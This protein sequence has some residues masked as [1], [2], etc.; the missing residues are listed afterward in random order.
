MKWMESSDE[1]GLDFGLFLSHSLLVGGVVVAVILGELLRLDSLSF[2]HSYHSHSLSL[3]DFVVAFD[4]DSA[5]SFGFV[6]FASNVGLGFAI[7]VRLDDVVP[8]LAFSSVGSGL[9][10]CFGNEVKEGFD[11]Y[12]ALYRQLVAFELF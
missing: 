1:L 4:D 2:R 12:L 3:V 5:V 11:N 6:G 7:G 10:E 8:F 9:L